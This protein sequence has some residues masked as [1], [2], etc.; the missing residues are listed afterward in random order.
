MA[1]NGARFDMAVKNAFGEVTQ[2][3]RLTVKDA[4]TSTLKV[5]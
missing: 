5:R 2:S 3:A 4:T 1:D